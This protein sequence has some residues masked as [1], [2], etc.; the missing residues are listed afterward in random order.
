MKETR[1]KPADPNLLLRGIVETIPEGELMARAAKRKLRVKFGA[2]PTAPDL[3]L[4]HMV[5]LR[6]LRQFQE[7][8][9]TVVFIIGD[10]TARVGD[11]SGRNT[12]RPPL[13]PKTI[14]ANAKTYMDQ[15]FRVLDKKKTEIVHNSQW[16]S[17][18]N[19]ADVLHLAAAGTIARMIE[20]DD[21]KG[22]FEAKIPI[23]IHE[24][25]YPL[26]QGYDSVAVRADVE[27]GGSDQKFNLLVGRDL[28]EKAGQ[29]PQAILTMPLLVGTDG[30]QKMSK[31]YGNYIA[32]GDS[33]ED[34]YGKVMSIP[35]GLLWDYWLLLTDRP[36]SEI[37]A[38]KSA[39][40]A[41]KE[42]PR[43]VKADLAGRL[44]SFFHGPAAASDAAKHFESVFVQKDV[45]AGIEDFLVPRDA[46]PDLP[47][48]LASA[49]LASS[50]SE[51]RRLIQQG[52][53]YINGA[54]HPESAPY[55]PKDGDILKVGKRKFLRLRLERK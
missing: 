46:P 36:E 3:H 23:G 9:H 40:A 24:F 32:F 19:F 28:Q 2:D 39:C 53:V 49:R 51:A 43:N 27:L 54:R 37:S 11:P 12:T 5:V 48:L 14:E 6:K 35:D 52:G 4:G 17:K 18:M 45:P 20:R 50:K 41:G 7:L 29:P 15:V 38:L 30:R 8:G 33:P 21:F 16:L 1:T 55:A 22:R 42:N 25:L 44:V 13:D 10:F 47:G 31:S 26:M 34:F